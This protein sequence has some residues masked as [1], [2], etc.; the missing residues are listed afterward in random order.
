MKYSKCER[1]YSRGV[2][3]NAAIRAYNKAVRKAAKLQL[4]GYIEKKDKDYF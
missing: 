3:T 1:K 2:N 4:H